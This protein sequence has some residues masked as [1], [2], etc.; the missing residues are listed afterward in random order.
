MTGAGICPT[1]GSGLL[2]LLPR[3]SM[4]GDGRVQPPS[5]TCL[6]DVPQPLTGSPVLSRADASVLQGFCGQPACQLP[7]DQLSALLRSLASRQVPLKA[8]QVGSA[9]EG[10]Q[11]FPGHSC[12]GTHLL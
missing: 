11:G 4:L 7:R 10:G 8:W 6:W 2:R 5:R 9:A 12:P 1:L 3:P